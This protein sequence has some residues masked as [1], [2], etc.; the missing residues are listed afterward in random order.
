MKVLINRCFG[1]FSISDEAKNLYKE[2]SGVKDYVSSYCEE[3]RDDPIL[4]NIV[5]ELGELAYDGATK[6][7]IYEVPEGY[8]YR[9]HNYDGFETIHL[10]INED[11]LRELIRLGNED[12]I[13]KYVMRAG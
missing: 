11:Y 12:D 4:I 1:G 13:V 6:L 8:S 5:E 2:R 7:M 9:V 10:K 3:L